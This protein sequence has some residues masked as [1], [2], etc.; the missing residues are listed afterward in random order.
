VGS[1]CAFEVFVKSKTEEH[2][3]A[4]KME[5]TMEKRKKNYI[6]LALII[7]AV[8]VFT[9]LAQTVGVKIQTVFLDVI[10]TII[11]Y[12]PFVVLLYYLGSDE[13]LNK[14]WRMIFRIAA[15]LMAASCLFGLVFTLY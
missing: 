7:A 8:L 14:V 10:L 11:F 12:S 9:K 3:R 6:I 4:F 13:R 15:I 5:T 2:E 1:C